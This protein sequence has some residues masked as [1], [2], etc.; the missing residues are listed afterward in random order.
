MGP[1]RVARRTR[2][3]GQA[4]KPAGA[5]AGSPPLFVS[6]MPPVIVSPSGRPAFFES[7]STSASDPV[8]A[9]S[10]S[11]APAVYTSTDPGVQPPALVRPQFPREPEPGDDTG[12]FDIVVDEQGNVERVKLLSPRRLFQERMLVAAA[13]AWK[14]RP[15]ILEGEYVKYRLRVPIILTGMP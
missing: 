9:S 12:Y 13:K 14:F 2:T 4:T 10:R 1:Q 11:D 5:A 7:L 6:A 15:A 8:A 3:D